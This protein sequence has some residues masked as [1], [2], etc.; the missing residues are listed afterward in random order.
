MSATASE[1]FEPL[2]AKLLARFEPLEVLGQGASGLVLRAREHGLDREVVLK[3]LR[4]QVLSSTRARERFLQEAQ[5]L[6]GLSHPNLVQ[7]L[8]YGLL[9]RG[10]YMVFPDEGGRSL[11]HVLGT[12]GTLGQGPLRELLDQMLAGLECLHGAGWVHRDVKPANILR[13]DDGTYRL[14]DLGLVR[15]LEG[16]AGLTATGS[17]VGTP[18][19]MAPQQ[20]A[21]AEPDATDDL[22]ALGLVAYVAASGSNPMRGASMHET[23]RRQCEE[24]PPP[25]ASVAPDMPSDLTELI[26][27]MVRKGR[28]KRPPSAA[29]ART[30]LE[31]PARH[32]AAPRRQAR[33]RRP[34]LRGVLTLAVGVALAWVVAHPLSAPPPTQAPDPILAPRSPPWLEALGEEIRDLEPRADLAPQEWAKVRAGLSSLDAFLRWHDA[35]GGAEAL[36]P[37]GRSRARDLDS[38]LGSLG[39]P[40]V[41]SPFLDLRP[42][43]ARPPPDSRIDYPRR[44]NGSP[45]HASTPWATSALATYHAGIADRIELGER[46]RAGFREGFP[47]TLSAST[48]AGLMGISLLADWHLDIDRFPGLVAPRLRRDPVVRTEV[49]AWIGPG[50]R[51]TRDLVA[52]AAQAVRREGDAAAWVAGDLFAWLEHLRVFHLASSW[53]GP[54]GDLTGVLPRTPSEHLVHASV[55]L[56]VLRIRSDFGDKDPG[57]WATLGQHLRRALAGV[58]SPE[59]DAWRWVGA[60]ECLTEA[61]E[62]VEE[63]GVVLGRV[64]PATHPHDQD[65]WRRVVLRLSAQARVVASQV[66]AGS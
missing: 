11:D 31:S 4:T 10:A 2:P 53:H 14:L 48:R 24:R 52:V 35:G 55:M 28:G 60:L 54:V 33:L 39:Y 62:H 18:A 40:R 13:C 65:W 47:E 6:A 50:Q 1:S 23:M 3:L 63:E 38:D 43:P 61:R 17:I 34:L 37:A 19:F 21:G 16:G 20:V 8:D 26:D 51:R 46:L 25:L 15:D 42:V 9:D 27:S 36:G 66:A 57:A 32:R 30:R 49:L 7:L 29:S 59:A 45:P 58:G 44:R 56:S 5:V 12:Q 41:L 64:L 22:Y